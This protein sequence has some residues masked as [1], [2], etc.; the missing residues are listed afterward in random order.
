MII[1]ICTDILERFKITGYALP[2]VQ[3]K[4]DAVIAVALYTNY[5]TF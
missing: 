4:T 2:A 5:L 1:L 3:Y